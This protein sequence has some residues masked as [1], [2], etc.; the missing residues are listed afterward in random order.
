MKRV[1]EIEIMP[2][3]S[4]EIIPDFSREF[5][6]TLSRAEISRYFNSHVPWHW[7]SAAELFYIESGDLEYVTPNARML[8]P[9]GAGG[10]INSGVLHMTRARS[11][12]TV[13]L[14]HLFE[15][16]LIS[17][18]QDGAIAEKYVLPLLTSGCEI[19]PIAPEHPLMD[20]IRASFLLDESEW[21]FELNVRAALSGIWLQLAK[22]AAETSTGA[23]LPKE[24]EK[25][26]RMMVYVH[27]HYAEK[28]C[29]A[30]LAAAAYCCER[31]C[32][33]LFQKHL[34]CSPL[35]YITSYRLQTACDMLR[36]E[37]ASIT[38]VCHSC[39]YETSS[40][41]GKVFAAHFGCTPREYRRKWQDRDINRRE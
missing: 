40:H 26:K 10:F 14:L 19:I 3:S 16:A 11:D 18:A 24:N 39:G 13:Q 25:L 34:H 15:P 12:K 31:E 22:I 30:D 36:H 27:Q 32:Y 17:G 1:T 21:G 4:R 28:L 5:P 37:N 35:E 38:G 20:A 29:V 2:G 41:F 23:R 33:R 8:F 9:Q 7:H 6:Y